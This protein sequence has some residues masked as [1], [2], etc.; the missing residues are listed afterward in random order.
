MCPNRDDVHVRDFRRHVGLGRGVTL[1]RVRRISLTIQILEAP[2]SLAPHM[3]GRVVD[4]PR[5]MDPMDERSLSESFAKQY[6][7][8]CLQPLSQLT[9]QLEALYNRSLDAIANHNVGTPA[10]RVALIISAR[11]ADDLRVCSLAS[12]IGYGLQ[13]L[14]LAG[15]VMELV[16]SLAYV[17]VSDERAGSWAKHAD[18]RHSYPRSVT[19]G[20]KAAL[21]AMGEHDPAA[22][23]NWKKSYEIM[24]MAKHVNPRLSLVHGLR[25]DSLGMYFVRGPDSSDLGT[26]AV[27]QAMHFSVSCG[28]TGIFIALAHCAEKRLREQLRSEAITVLRDL[29]ALD[30]WFLAIGRSNN[31]SAPP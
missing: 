13:A 29:R 26:I 28:A 23:D 15:T 21:E 20:I 1:G 10:S 11:L 19:D 27:A 25:E 31:K 3:M 12:H 22:I 17:S 6:F 9:E 4:L 2:E 16:G 8:E 24:C 30:S 14:V 5:A 18:S 7:G